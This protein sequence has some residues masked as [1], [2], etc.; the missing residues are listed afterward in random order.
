LDGFGRGFQVLLGGGFI[1]GLG[2]RG[3]PLP[4]VPW[5]AGEGFRRFWFRG[6][7]FR[8]FWFRGFWFR[9]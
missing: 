9:G 2:F 8:G 4:A 1:R 7:G 6:K 5:H 3:V